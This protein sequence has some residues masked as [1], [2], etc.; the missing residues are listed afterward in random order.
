MKRILLCLFLFELNRVGSVVH[1]EDW[2]QWR[3]PTADGVAGV[4]AKPPLQWDANTNVAWVA[5]LLGEGSAT[6]IVVGDQIFVLAAEQTPRKSPTAV[7]ND[8]RAKTVPDEF[9]Y[10]F[11]VTSIDRKTGKTLWQRVATEQVPHEGR[12]PTNTY[13]AGSPT[14]DGERLYVSFGSRGIFCYS[15]TGE[16]VWEVDLGD[17]RT[18]FGWGEAV[19]PVLADE[20]LIINWDQ[21]EDS[22][23]VA[24][25]KR[26]GK[27]V[28]KNPRPEEVSSWNT[29]LV[30]E[31][32]GKSLVIV[33][34]TG[35]VRAY[36]AKTGEV[37]WQ[38]G[39]QTTNAIP[40][41]IRFNDSAIC[42]SGYRGAYACAIPL[43][44]KG[45]ITDKNVVRWQHKQGTPYV[46]SPIISGERLFFTGGNTDVLSCINARTGK[47]TMERRRL[48]DIKSFYASP[49]LAN[50]HL[51]FT[52]REGVTVILR[53]DEKLDVVAVNRLNDTIDASPVAVDN[54][55]FLRSWKKLYCI[56][57]ESSKSESQPNR[58]E[59]KSTPNVK[60]SFRQ[61]DLE[62]TSETS[63]NVS[64]GD[65]DSDGDLDIVL[66]KGRHWPL[67]NRI[68][69][70]DGRA[71]FSVAKNLGEV[72]DRTYSTALADLDNDG[73]IDVLVSNDSPDAKRIYFN[74]GK[75]NFSDGGTW[76][77]ASWNTRNTCLADLNG[78]HSPDL[79][80]ANRKSSS[81]V[82]VNDRRGGFSGI[83]RIEI[84]F[85]SASTI[86]PA[87]FNGDRLIDLAIPHRDG[88]QSRIFFN[89]K[90]TEFS[91]SATFGPPDI[92][93]RAAA[94]GDFNGDGWMDIVIG[95]ERR[96]AIVFLNDG[97]GGFTN[98]NSLG[99]DKRIPY[100]I[101]VGDINRDQKIDLVLG[102]AS[103]FCSVYFNDGTGRNFVEVPFGDGKG[104]V[105][106][107][108]LGDL[109]NDGQLD[110][111]VGRSDATNAV[112]L[113]ETIMANNKTQ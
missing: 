49:M 4:T 62:A 18:R 33:N 90:A 103:G 82:C 10:R 85:G 77:E 7:V 14:T 17:M 84:R 108:A 91:H 73:D 53:D 83:P 50:G 93:T 9:Y 1:S 27:T 98:S 54:Q 88:G 34:G 79:I 92:A 94:S 51:Y 72:P 52:G 6:P 57:E 30:T 39:G 63:A 11:S 58:T 22:F 2:V 64:L 38:C 12:H 74:D 112:F 3:G 21:E 110:V 16:L 67:H 66:A 95:E 68:L 37:Y 99:D 111:A 78:D 31:Y 60:T 24:L 100:S 70:N 105:Y 8:E 109:D 13:A 45:D 35:R 56:Q 86:V 47:A 20:L 106:G 75:A 36:D 96:G 23:I 76:G 104:S 102:Y 113:N 61:I 26:T 46:P 44:S 71:Q 32:E 97:R 42:M 5:E 69:L 87:D 48:E 43:D 89:D 28:W 80:A 107:I 40:S 19:T 29:P 81:F 25:D 65:L 15:L 59:S 101:A 55:L 41:P